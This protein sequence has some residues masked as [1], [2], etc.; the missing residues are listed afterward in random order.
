MSK[1]EMGLKNDSGLDPTHI[2][3]VCLGL[4]PFNTSVKTFL[5]ELGFEN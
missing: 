4:M 2:L 3:V 5:E 1:N